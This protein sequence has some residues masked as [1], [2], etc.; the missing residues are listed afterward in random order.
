MTDRL[1]FP[2]ARS[3]LRRHPEP[4]DPDSF[5]SPFQ[6]D[7]DRIV[8]SRAFRRLAAKTQVATLPASSHCRNR[9]THT[10]EV[11]QIARTV[12]VAL[13][14][15][16]DL[17]EALALSHD[18]GHP[19]FGHTGEDALNA[20]M[21]QLG[22]SFDHNAHALR[23]VEHFETRYARF[24][25]LNLTFEV[26]EGLVKHS[27][28]LDPD[29]SRYQEYLP[30]RRPP[31]EA[32]LI[33]PADEIAYLTADMEDALEDGALDIATLCSAVPAFSREFEKVRSSH[34]TVGD[35]RALR[36]AQRNLVGILVRGLVQGTTE[37][38]QESGARDYDGVRQLAGRIAVPTPST[39]H[40]M[41]QIRAILTSSY[42]NAAAR[43]NAASE[44]A[45][46]LRELF[47][48]YV[49][50]PENLPASHAS[51]LT[52]EPAHQ[53]VCDYVAGMTDVYALQRHWEIL[54]TRTFGQFRKA[55]A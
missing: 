10:I 29:D 47:R 3:R 32:Q 9:L 17:T 19:P 54:G 7:R 6:H 44:Y 36:E 41:A 8:H 4:A 11:S 28:D 40:T 53:V 45:E 48:H 22:L 16:T 5:R 43:L 30:L 31:L 27:R 18:I 1:R 50:Y 23:I 52:E 49:A 33:D 12:A 34:P 51:Q 15:N 21:Q 39:R 55:A 46:A 37:A 25:G 35:R 42:Y 2:S 26:R 14:L 13:G 24:R 20:E 38:A